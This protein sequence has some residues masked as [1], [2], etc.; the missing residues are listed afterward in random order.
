MEDYLIL[1][2]LALIFSIAFI[3]SVISAKIKIPEVT[4]YVL[5]GV[6]MGHS[7]F[8]VFD[9]EVLE[10]FSILSTIS[11]GIIAFSIG[12]E[13]KLSTL[14]K[15]GKSI[16]LIVLLEAFGAFILVFLSTKFLLSLD[17]YIALLLGSVAAA[18]APAATV[19]V[20][21]QYKAKGNLTSTILAVVG[22]D[23]AI[24]LII[25]V[26]ASS[27][28]KSIIKGVDIDLLKLTFKSVGSIL[29]AVSV[30]AVVAFI[31]VFIQRLVRKK[32]SKGLSANKSIKITIVSS[33]F[34]MLGISE[35]LHISELLSI[36]T[37]GAIITNIAPVI[38]KKSESVI[39]F[40]TPIFLAIFFLM[41]GA[42]LD[43]TSITRIG[44]IGLVYFLARGIG[45]IS[46]GSLGAVLGNAS[47]NIKKYIGFALLPQVGVALALALSIEKDFTQPIYG[48]AGKYVADLVINVL[49]FTTILTEIIGPLL[50]KT[51]LVKSGEIETNIDKG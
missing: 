17:T 26:F 33:I 20:I 6:L 24:A 19:A 4:I 18:T 44:W 49:L 8:R 47:P 45:K 42:H 21:K 41:G 51:V 7:I 2:Y 50:T 28:S 9:V 39:E 12:V 37:F 16:F 15:V 25:F 5:V 46:G 43:V 27:F 34:F 35:Y 23:D 32:I 30:G 31:Y 48:E 36:M 3:D 38:T 40:F 22:I 10:A 1:I 11:L 29:L 13:L 14:K